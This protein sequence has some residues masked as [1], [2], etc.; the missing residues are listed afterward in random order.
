[1]AVSPVNDSTGVSSTTT[2]KTGDNL[3]KDD[4]LN[5]L[6]TQLRN[7]DPLNPMDDK[8]TIAQMA[9]FSALEQMQNL[10]S[11]FEMQQASGMIDKDIKA[12]VQN[13]NGISEVVYGRVTSVQK[14]DGV[15]YLN[16]SDGRQVKLDEVT[17]VLGT[18]GAWQEALTLV[19]HSVIMSINNGQDYVQVDITDAKTDD[20]GLIQLIGSDGKKYTMNQVY[21]VLPDPEETE[22]GN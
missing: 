1:M 8:D 11:A 20:N 22:S 4:F 18:N 12:E 2:R 16:L 10:N 19:G 13:K 5:L 7:Q 6:V 9:Q 15:L 3:G 21:Y 14:T 17:K